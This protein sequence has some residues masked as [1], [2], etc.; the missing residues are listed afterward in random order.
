MQRQR[1]RILDMFYL[2]GAAVLL[3]VL[4]VGAFIVADIY[5]VNPLWIMVSF[6]SVGFF[7]GAREDYRKELRSP[8]FVAFVC[9]WIVINVIVFIAL[10]SFL[11]WLCGLIPA[12]LL[13][14]FLFY[15]TAYWFFDVPPPSK[16][17]PFQRAESSDKD[18]S[19]LP[20][21]DWREIAMTLNILDERNGVNV[22]VPY[23]Q[24]EQHRGMVGLA[25]TYER[26]PGCAG[27]TERS[28]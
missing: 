14:Q 10:L 15:M 22:K 25:G 27:K 17:W 20:S 11:G 26:T 8:R 16:R 2:V 19:D 28:K 23:I 4:S 9:G 7:A 3:C 18:G 12:L 24:H 1:S 21:F 13:E 6:I 5:H